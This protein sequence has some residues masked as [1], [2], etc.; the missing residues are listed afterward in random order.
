[1]RLDGCSLLLRRIPSCP[2]LLGHR[3]VC[4]F[5]TS[6]LYL[7]LHLKVFHSTEYLSLLNSPSHIFFI[8]QAP[9]TTDLPVALKV[10][11]YKPLETVCNSLITFS[12]EVTDYR[13]TNKCHIRCF[14]PSNKSLTQGKRECRLVDL[15]FVPGRIPWDGGKLAYDSETREF[16][17]FSVTLTLATHVSSRGEKHV[18]GISRA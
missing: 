5:A 2:I 16:R 7:K 9:K 4:V 12:K 6:G 11:V 3:L 1:M 10:S 17:S 18:Q 15:G 13:Y 14:S 8:K